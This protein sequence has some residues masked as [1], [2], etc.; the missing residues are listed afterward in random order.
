MKSDGRSEVGG[1]VAGAWPGGSIFGSLAEASAFF[2]QGS[3]GYSATARPGEFDGLELRCFGWRAYPLAVERVES[4]FFGDR[5]RFPEGSAEFDCA[6]VMHGI[7]HEWHGL[8]GL[9]GDRNL[10]GFSAD[11]RS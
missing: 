7:A 6:L 8:P 11:A 4:S 5:S 1:R 3:R 2:E 10:R 9:R